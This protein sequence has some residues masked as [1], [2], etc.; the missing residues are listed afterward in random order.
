M[1]H[2]DIKHSAQSAFNW[3]RYSIDRNKGNG[4]SAYFHVLKSWGP[5]YP[6]T[7][8]YIIPTLLK[9]SSTFE[10]SYAY[11]LAEK[12]VHWLLSMQ[13][14]NGSI[15][16]STESKDQ[17]FVFD[18][19][20]IILGLCSFY[21]KHPDKIDPDKIKSI[22]SWLVNQIDYSGMFYKNTYVR[23]YSPTYLL[24]SVWA[25]AFAN[26]ILSLDI[27]QYIEQ[28]LEFYLSRLTKENSFLKMAIRPEDK[29][30]LT[31]NIAYTLR[32]LYE[33]SL[34]LKRADLLDL[35]RSSC[36][37]LKEDFVK[38]SRLAG[39]YNENWDGDSSF[40]C[41]TGN[42]QL[43]ILFKKLSA[44]DDGY[45]EV[46]SK[47]LSG[48]MRHQHSIGPKSIKGSIFSS[49]P[50]WGKYQRFKVTNWTMKFYLDALLSHYEKEA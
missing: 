25:L 14:K 26:E 20:Q 9:Y 34:I 29:Y 4:S 42:A 18:N 31:H 36:N 11:V 30:A 22:C 12:L 16:G 40:V 19:S 7:S 28:S 33:L 23:D 1:N 32:S 13:L 6:E 45:S 5:A 15:P 37:V 24:R 39:S 10:D 49:Q 50:I 43:S 47:L 44:N 48:L 3:I 35:C 21:D 8:G 27:D 38:N 41:N 17:A 46:S 2:S